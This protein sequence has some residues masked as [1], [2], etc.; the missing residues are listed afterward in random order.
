MVIIFDDVAMARQREQA[1]ST[2]ALCNARVF[3]WLPHTLSIFGRGRWRFFLNVACVIFVSY[4][5]DCFFA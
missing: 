4:G 5:M 2:L 3:F 1:H